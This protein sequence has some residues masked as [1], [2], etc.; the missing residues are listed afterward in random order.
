[1]VSFYSEFIHHRD[2]EDT[3][4]AQRLFHG[5]F[6]PQACQM[7]KSMTRILLKL[8]IALVTFEIGVTVNAIYRYSG[9]TDLVVPDYVITEQ[10]HSCFPGL[11]VRV[12]KS[13]DQTEFFSQA[14]LSETPRFARLL[15][16]WY[17]RQLEA[18]NERPLSALENEDESY[19]FLWL[20]TFHKPVAIHVWRAGAQHFVVVKRLNGRGGYDPGRFDLYW[21]HSLSENEWDAFMLH[22]EYAEYWLMP[23]EEKSLMFDGA[24]WIMEGYR[25]GRYHVVD[26]KSP[27]TGAYRDAC[28][29]LL[30]QSGLLAETPASEVY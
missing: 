30:R 10:R 18:M 15:N 3:E 14:A 29:Y 17:S 28:L 2:T 8:A 5:T 9:T 24:Q 16:G 7:V 1:M 6:L 19:R 26:R 20:R 23:T 4:V 12:L 13:S 25:E 21:S 27:D 11:S 22:L